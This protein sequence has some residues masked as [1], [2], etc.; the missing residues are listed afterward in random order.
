[1]NAIIRGVVRVVDVG[2]EGKSDRDA[3]Q[4]EPR[5]LRP[6]CPAAVCCPDLVDMVQRV[7]TTSPALAHVSSTALQLQEL[8]AIDFQAPAVSEPLHK[9]AAAGI[10]LP[11]H[12]SPNLALQRT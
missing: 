1:M 6:A 2:D 3:F 4:L 9:S 7:F 11:V 5:L 8:R 10:L 12:L